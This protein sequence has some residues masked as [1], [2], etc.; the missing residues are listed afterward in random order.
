MFNLSVNIN[1][2]KT[3]ERSNRFRDCFA[4]VKTNVNPLTAGYC[5]QHQMPQKGNFRLLNSTF[6]PLT[7]CR[8][9]QQMVITVKET[10]VQGRKSRWTRIKRDLRDAFC[11][12][13]AL[14]RQ[15]SSH[16]HVTMYSSILVR[17][18]EFTRSILCASVFSSKLKLKTKTHTKD[19]I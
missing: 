11:Q 15:N 7:S 9:H 12:I 10:K 4:C 19:T 6:R 3:T 13:Y 18:M 5:T 8:N 17:F 14:H 2:G 1:M 16:R